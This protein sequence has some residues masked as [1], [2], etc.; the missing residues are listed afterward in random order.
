MKTY[1]VTMP[2]AGAVCVRVQ[3]NSPEEAIAAAYEPANDLIASWKC[4]DS[5]SG[6]LVELEVH[7]K[8]SEGN[9]NHLSYSRAEAEEE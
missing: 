1:N 4:E 6:S 2:I 7:E 3:A 5:E 9:V 8:T